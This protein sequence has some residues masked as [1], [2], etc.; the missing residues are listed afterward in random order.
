MFNRG[1][2]SPVVEV[3]PI[4][5]DEQSK[6]ADGLKQQAA[7]QAITTRSV[8]YYIFLV[9]S[10]ILFICLLY[11]IFSPWEMDHQKVFENYIPSYGFFSFYTGSIFCYLVCAMVVKV[12]SIYIS[13]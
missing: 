5:E 6:I 2:S 8:F 1:K 3:V 12:S 9:V 7:A 4:D 10:L 13:V 11:S